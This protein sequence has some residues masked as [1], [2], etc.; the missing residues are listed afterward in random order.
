MI[1]KYKVKSCCGSESLIIET[2]Y[3]IKKE[4]I[5]IFEENKYMIPSHFLKAGIFYVQK[6]GL[7]STSSFGSNKLNVR[8][9]GQNCEKLL[10]EF[11]DLLNNINK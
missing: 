9:G 10:I 4:H 11:E 6:D 3:F 5:S 8:C 7:I 1:K 2:P